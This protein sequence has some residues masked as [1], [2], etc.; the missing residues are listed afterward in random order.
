MDA[1]RFSTRPWMACRKIPAALTD[2]SG[3]VSRQALSLVTFF[4]QAKKV[5]RRKAEAFDLAFAGE[6]SKNNRNGA[7][8]PGA[9]ISSA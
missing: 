8:Y 6:N 2:A 7:A 9:K 4:G 5:T 1:R 3:G